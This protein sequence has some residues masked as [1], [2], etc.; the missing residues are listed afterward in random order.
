MARSSR[1]LRPD[2]PRQW[3][4]MTA[5]LLT[6]ALLAACGGNGA[7]SAPQTPA[8]D[9]GTVIQITGQERLGWAQPATASISDLHFAAYVDGSSRSELASAACTAL[10]DQSYSC[11]SPLP[12]LSSGRHSLELVSWVDASGEIL[13]SA[14]SPAL[15]LQVSGGS[16]ESRR[17]D[18]Q[19]SASGQ[20]TVSHLCGVHTIL[21]AQYWKA[22]GSL[23]TQLPSKPRQSRR[24]RNPASR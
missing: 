10:A 13:E 22:E 9:P 8:P 2:L 11:E 3:H 16:A 17:T 18:G 21:A 6:A 23:R 15:T 7:P 1:S 5:C 20:T 24:W 4:L 14:R 19:K 12:P